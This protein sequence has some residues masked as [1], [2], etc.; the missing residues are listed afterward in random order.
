MTRR[1]LLHLSVLLLAACDDDPPS[2]VGDW[3]LTGVDNEPLPTVVYEQDDDT[4]VMI[5]DRLQLLDGDVYERTTLRYVVIDGVGDSV[6]ASTE[7]EWGY[8]GTNRIWLV[9]G[10][11]D[12][13]PVLDHL[14]V[15]H[16]EMRNHTPEGVLQYRREGDSDD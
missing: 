6:T 10:P 15:L 12:H 7:G 8:D 11:G 14:Y 5:S 1:I 9:L 13:G 4:V 16:G 3:V 2:L